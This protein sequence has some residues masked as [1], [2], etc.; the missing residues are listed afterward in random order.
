MH[1]T[2][3]P[4]PATID[5]AGTVLTFTL[6]HAGTGN[7]VIGSR[8]ARWHGEATMPAARVLRIPDS[9][10]SPA[11]MANAPPTTQNLSAAKSRA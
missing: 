6:N 4:H 7:A 3:L 10:T 9:A 11:H 1:N 2:S 5:R 8:S